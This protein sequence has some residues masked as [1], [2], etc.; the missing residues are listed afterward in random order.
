MLY[1][2]SYGIYTCHKSRTPKIRAALRY[3][4]ATSVTKWWTPVELSVRKG[5][6]VDHMNLSAPLQGTL[7]ALPHPHAFSPAASMT[8]V[9][10]TTA[11]WALLCG[12]SIS[13]HAQPADT[14]V[15][16]LATAVNRALEISPEV[17][18][19]AAQQEFAE[20]R[21]RLAR[22]SRFLTEFSAQSAHAVAPGLENPNG[23]NLDALYID[24][25]VRNDWSDIAPFNV[26]EVEALQPLFTW[27]QLSGSIE[28]AQ[29]GVAV[30]AAKVDR[31]AIDVAYRTAELYYSL[32]L[33]DQLAQLVAETG[34]IVDQAKR[35]INGLLEEGAEGV[36][37]ADL[38]QV[39]ITEQE[40][41][42]RVVEIEERQQ[43]A[44]T[45]LRRQL[46]LPDGTT[47]RPADV[48]LEPLVFELGM[49]N[50][51]MAA[52]IANRPELAQARAG[53]AARSAL[54]DVAKS[55]LYPKLF[56]GARYQTR[57]A[58]GR[59]KPLNPYV[60]DPYRGIRFEAGLGLRQQLNFGQTRARIQ[61]AQAEYA[62]VTFQQEAA[63][64]LIQ[65]EL[66]DA[67]R[68]VRIA[69]AALDAAQ[70]A[71]RLGK[72][73]LGFET[74]NFELDIGD[75]E[76]LVNAVRQSLTLEAA[77]FEA[78]RQYNLSILKLWRAEGTLRQRLNGGTLVD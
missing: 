53:V 10:R 15:V 66:E 33:T 3:V 51:H 64:Q 56:L 36:D 50:D 78:I 48:S 16:D 28:A 77:Y 74:V 49:L 43:T 31:K 7:R 21:A 6:S 37:D 65:F 14:L 72:E 46:F 26:V 5:L 60:G 63:H 58:T 8:S 40:Y 68:N 12:V 52:A 67:Y 55:D 54:V 70:E 76:N 29:Q 4:Q 73:W 32:L 34:R 38:F 27:G 18:Q 11:W 22:S 44:Q 9:V 47:A 35:E 69:K 41:L 62:E 61:Q 30:E 25:D 39:L 17:G 13:L 45:A 59:A 57:Y 19:V 20:A 1:Q 2:L 71:L 75:T 24:P 42:R 23:T